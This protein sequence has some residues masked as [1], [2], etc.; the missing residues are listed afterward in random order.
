MWVIFIVSC[1]PTIRPLFVK[2]FSKVYGSGSRPSQGYQQQSD[3][4]KPGLHTRAYASTFGSRNAVE[5]KTSSLPTTGDNESEETILP[6]Q[7]GIMMTSQVVIKYDDKQRAEGNRDWRNH[8]DDS[9]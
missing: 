1:I 4:A 3:P 6:G 2:A 9:V 7:R 5:S 8:F